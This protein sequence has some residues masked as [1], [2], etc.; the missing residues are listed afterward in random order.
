MSDDSTMQ[1]VI[2]P[3]RSPGLKLARMPIPDVGAREV[4]IKVAATSI[5]WHR[6]AHLQV[7]SLGEK[8]HQSS[9]HCRP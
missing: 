8:P 9:S 5:L 1:A 6:S 4:L 3:D 2:K 7:V